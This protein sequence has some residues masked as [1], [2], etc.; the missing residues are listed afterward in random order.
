[1]EVSLHEAGGG[2]VGFRKQGE[3]F[4]LDPKFVCAEF[5]SRQSAQRVARRTG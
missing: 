3:V 2:G 5:C 1:M 4:V